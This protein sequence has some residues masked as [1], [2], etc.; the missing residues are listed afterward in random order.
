MVWYWYDI[1]IYILLYIIYNNCY[2]FYY[3]WTT[4]KSYHGYDPIVSFI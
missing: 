1:I 4:T 3:I 2:T